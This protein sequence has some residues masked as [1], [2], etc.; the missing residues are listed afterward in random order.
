[1]IPPTAKTQSMSDTT[2]LPAQQP[3]CHGSSWP[4]Q[5]GESERG[6]SLILAMVFLV[7]TSLVVTGLAD[8]VKNDLNNTVKFTSAES[9]QSTANSAAE[10]AI[11]SVRYNFTAATLNASPP[12]PCWTPSATPSEITLNG[13]S[14]SAWCT[15]RWDPLSTSTR[16]VTVMACQSGTTASQCAANPVLY[17]VVTFDDYP[18]PK[19][20]VTSA[21]C[22][23]TCGL[24]MT[25]NDWVFGDVPPTLSGIVPTTGPPA[26]GSLVTLSGTGFVNGAAVNFVGTNLAGNVILKSG[27]VTVLS[28]TSMTALSPK[29]SPGASYYVTVTTPAGTSAYGPVF[30]AK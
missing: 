27:T 24:G 1:M 2:R 14:V 20:A 6:S 12:Q 13:Q 19:G 8:W 26:P 5:S 22:T 15:T 16:V 18:S 11:Q 7:V 23:S 4:R 28:P 3:S 10:L 30:T 21:Q 25:I 9:L 29:L 17:A